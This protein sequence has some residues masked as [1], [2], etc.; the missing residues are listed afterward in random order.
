M[1]AIN[2]ILVGLLVGRS[3]VGVEGVSKKHPPIHVAL[4]VRLGGIH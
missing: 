2:P 1:L 4:L 3:M